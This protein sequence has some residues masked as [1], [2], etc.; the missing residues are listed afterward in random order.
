MSTIEELIEE[1]ENSV[2]LYYE[3][4]EIDSVGVPRMAV[5]EV[6]YR[7]GLPQST[8]NAYW[9]RLI[10]AAVDKYETLTEHDNF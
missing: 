7:I 2:E 8:I 1:V 3:E 9:D 6:L 5:E 10:R 4:L